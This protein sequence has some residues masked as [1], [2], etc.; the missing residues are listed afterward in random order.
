MNVMDITIIHQGDTVAIK[1]RFP[2]RLIIKGGGND[3]N[4]NNII[5]DWCAANFEYSDV[6]I[7]FTSV[8]FRNDADAVHAKLMFNELERVDW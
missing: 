3:I 4:S 7:M 1:K 6:L 8:A 2:F 5:K